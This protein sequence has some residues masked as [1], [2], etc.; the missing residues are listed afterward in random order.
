LYEFGKTYQTGNEGY[1]EFEFLSL[2]LCGKSHSESW[3]DA[4]KGDADLFELK[5]WVQ[6][7]LSRIGINN[8]QCSAIEEDK[9]FDFGLQYHRGPLDIVKFGKV[10]S[11]TAKQMGVNQNVY[12]A[13]FDF[14]NVF[15]FA[16]KNTTEIKEISKYPIVRRDIALVLDEGI[17]FEEI[18]KLTYKTEKQLIREINLFDIYKNE[19]QLG[20]GKKSYAVSFTFQDDKQTLRDIDIDKVINKL[21]TA[22]E[23]QLKAQIR[24]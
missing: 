16:S 4:N 13:L 24:S 15:L 6:R 2:F 17:N 18:Q 3:S 14:R 8:Y 20:K 21:I 11:V 5:K 9:D 7:A 10:A 22:F 1:A 23:T 12:Y 19:K